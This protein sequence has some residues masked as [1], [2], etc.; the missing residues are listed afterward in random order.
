MQK[1]I[2]II[3]LMWQIATFF[4]HKRKDLACSFQTTVKKKFFQSGIGGICL[5]FC[6]EQML[7]FFC[8]EF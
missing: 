1:Y 4:I 5:F 2:I 7:Q 8:A 6:R 3:I